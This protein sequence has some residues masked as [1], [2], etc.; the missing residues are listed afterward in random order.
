MPSI[1]TLHYSQNVEKVSAAGTLALKKKTF[2][3]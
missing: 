2:L 1:R 3:V